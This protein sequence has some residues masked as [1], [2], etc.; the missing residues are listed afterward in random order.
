MQG[1]RERD[2]DGIDLGVGEQG[3]IAPV[4]AEDA[5]LRR[6]RLGLCDLAATHGH[7]LDPLGLVGCREDLVVDSRGRQ[8]AEA[9][10]GH[11]SSLSS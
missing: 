10:R 1:I 3:L 8:Q 4:R 7:D 6:I 11:R 9:E 5:V 2:V